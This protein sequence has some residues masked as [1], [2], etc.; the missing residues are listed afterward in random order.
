MS[1]TY[2]V[3]KVTSAD[4][5][6]IGYRQ[7]GSG[8]GLILVHGGMMGAQSFMKLGQMLASDFTVYIVDRRGRGLSGPHGDYSLAKESQDIRAVIKA[9]G[10]TNIFGLSA[11]GIVALQT[12]LDEPS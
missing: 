7:L 1:N 2:T 12:V 5:T 4:G 8:P 3:H 6:V 9:T 10:S 11:G